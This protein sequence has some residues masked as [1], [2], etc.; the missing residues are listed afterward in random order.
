MKKLLTAVAILLTPMAHAQKATDYLDSLSIRYVDIRVAKDNQW[1]QDGG[2]L[3]FWSSLSPVGLN[4]TMSQ[5]ARVSIYLKK[6][7][8]E[9]QREW[10]TLVIPEW[11]EKWAQDPAT[12]HL[13]FST[14]NASIKWADSYDTPTEWTDII[15][16]LKKDQYSVIVMRRQKN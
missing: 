10:K 8:G 13:A 1:G 16:T 3:M 7:Y 5:F 12:G 15:V 9:P 6:L 11:A 2:D 4:E 14:D